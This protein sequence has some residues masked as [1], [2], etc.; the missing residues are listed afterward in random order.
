MIRCLNANPVQKS[1]WE[2][3][4]RVATERVGFNGSFARAR[5]GT[6]IFIC[7]FLGTLKA[8]TLA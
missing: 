2:G 3:F 7:I 6:S 4:I 5:A 1:S 8:P